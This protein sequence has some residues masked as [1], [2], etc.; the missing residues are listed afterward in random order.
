M[1]CYRDMT[2]CTA[3]CAATDC[4]RKLTPEVKE[5][6]VKWW[7]DENAPISVSDLSEMCKE[8]EEVKE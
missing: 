8:F 1:I 6:A 2:F 7:G 4:H 5:A 3:K